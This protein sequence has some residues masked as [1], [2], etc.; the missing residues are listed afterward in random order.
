MFSDRVFYG[1]R[2]FPH[3]IQAAILFAGFAKLDK[4]GIG[5]AT[6]GAKVGSYFFGH[7]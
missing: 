4:L 6:A 5:L 3:A 1:G 7:Y 2:A